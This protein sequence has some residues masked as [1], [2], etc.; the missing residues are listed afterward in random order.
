MTFLRIDPRRRGWL[1]GGAIAVAGALLL[2][3]PV[4]VPYTIT[5]P[6]KI[7]CANEWVVALNRDGGIAAFVADRVSGVTRQYS[8]A[9]FNRGDAVSFSIDPRIT[10][11]VSVHAGDTVGVARSSEVE[12]ELERLRGELRNAI[13]SLAVTVTGEKQA[14]VEEAAQTVEHAKRQAEDLDA[15]YARQ[16][17]LFEKGLVSEQEFDLA[18]R[19][20][21][22]AQIEVSIAE[23]RLRSVTTGAKKE[24]TEFVRSQILSLQNEIRALE[25]HEQGFRLISPVSGIVTQMGGS[26]TLLVVSDTTSY[27]VVMPVPVH[28]R[29]SVLPE[30]QVRISATEVAGIPGASVLKVDRAI[31]SLNGQQVV[32]ATAQM[33]QA[34]AEVLNG[35]LA[36][37][38][39]DCAS[40]TPWEYAGRKF[41]S[42]VR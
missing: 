7:L 29:T 12:R 14:I 41:R 33:H 4:S 25:R 22:T 32:F 17:M 28:E 8:L 19:R 15:V 26:D 6:G 40:L 9:Q 35:L 13:A 30:Q 23:A 18:Q 5:A 24:Q 37:C 3:L 2:L 36:R 38:T 27:V 16:K 21:A 10:T 31:Q 34:P 1:I 42:L 39:I 20:A 11:G